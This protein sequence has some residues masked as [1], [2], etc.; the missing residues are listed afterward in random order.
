MATRVWVNND[1]NVTTYPQA[2]F[3]LYLYVLFEFQDA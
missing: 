1:E 3:E 2:E